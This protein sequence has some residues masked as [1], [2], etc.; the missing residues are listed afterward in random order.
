MA[1]KQR[2]F[3]NKA[4]ADEDDGEDGPPPIRPPQHQPKKD[5]ASAVPK[6]G[7]SGG[8]VA[9]AKGDT[10]KDSKGSKLNLLSFEDEGDDPGFVRK[11]DTKKEKQRQSKLARAPALPELSTDNAPQTFRST[12]GGRCKAERCRMSPTT[13]RTSVL[14][15]LYHQLCSMHTHRGVRIIPKTRAEVLPQVGNISQPAPRVAPPNK[16]LPPLIPWSRLTPHVH[17]SG[18]LHPPFVPVLPLASLF[19]HFTDLTVLNEHL[20]AYMERSGPFERL[21]IH[22]FRPTP[23]PSIAPSRVAHPPCHISFTYVSLLH[24]PRMLT[25]ENCRTCVSHAFPRLTPPQVNTLQ[26]G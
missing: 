9:S 1:F 14:W 26:S 22:T 15:I 6:P 18:S 24:I 19:S 17:R 7:L 3:R 5:H 21:T 23:G 4:T 13:R 2:K 8:T 11:K 20:L 16:C 10:K 25:V 12:A